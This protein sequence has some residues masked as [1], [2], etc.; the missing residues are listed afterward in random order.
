VFLDLAS[1]HAR[2]RLDDGGRLVLVMDR[3]I[4]HAESLS[5]RVHTVFQVGFNRTTPQFVVMAVRILSESSRIKLDKTGKLL[6]FSDQ[7]CW[8]FL[9]GMGSPRK[10]GNNGIQEVVGST[11][12]GSWC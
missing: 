9:P 3:E 7:R 6:T 5:R 8:I 12:I 2:S 10:A 11:P 4:S 1:D